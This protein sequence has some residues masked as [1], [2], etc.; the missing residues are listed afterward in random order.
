MVVMVVSPNAA[1][2]RKPNVERPSR[3]LDPALKAPISRLAELPKIEAGM[4]VVL[5]VSTPFTH[6]DNSVEGV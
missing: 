6:R 5:T 1:A 4:L 3:T 2:Q